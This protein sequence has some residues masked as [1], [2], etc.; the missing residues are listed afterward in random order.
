[1]WNIAGLRHRQKSAGQMHLLISPHLQI[2][3][4][5]IFTLRPPNIRRCGQR[6]WSSWTTISDG[7]QKTDGSL[8]RSIPK[9]T[10][11]SNLNRSKRSSSADM[12][13]RYWSFT[14]EKKISRRYDE[15][16]SL[17]RGTDPG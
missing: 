9:N 6:R 17:L 8:Y 12:A 14:K 13:A 4:S 10:D 1:M 5:N 16:L 7:W 15:N 11:R 3:H 2:G